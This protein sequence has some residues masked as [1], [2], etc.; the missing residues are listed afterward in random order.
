MPAAKASPATER[1]GLFEF[2]GYKRQALITK[3]Q[4]LS[5]EQA[6]MTPTASSLSLL[7][8]VKHSAIWE[9]RWFQVIVAGRSFP[10]E[11]PEVRSEEEDSTFQ[12]TDEDTVETVVA[13][14]REQI[15]ASDEILGTFDLE[16]P[17][18]WP[19]M[20]EQNL[21]WVALHMIEET[22]H[23]AGHADIIRETIDGS[24]WR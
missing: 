10:G 6:R 2:L 15:A 22:A 20:A 1:A 8:L 24:R 7:S 9:R 4:G 5:E 12:L 3:L 21:R 18:A 14:Y 11:W 23:H 13:D 19:E 16:A 17:C